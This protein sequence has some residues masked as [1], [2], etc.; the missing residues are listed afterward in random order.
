MK[1]LVLP[2]DQFPGVSI[3][4]Y[5]SPAS[6]IHFLPVFFSIVQLT[7]FG[8]PTDIFLQGYS[9]K[10]TAQFFLLAFFYTSPNCPNIF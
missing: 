3:P 4:S 2:Q 8:F 6:N 7:Y 10:L 1:D 9:S 5:F